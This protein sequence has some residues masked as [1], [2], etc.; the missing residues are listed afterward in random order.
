MFWDQ[1]NLL[2][3]PCFKLLTAGTWLIFAIDDDLINRV[4]FLYLKKAFH[5]LNR[6]ILFKELQLYVL[7]PH[8]VMW[9]KSHLSNRFQ[10]TCWWTLSDY[11]PVSCGEPQGSVLG[12][13]LFLAININE[14]QECELLMW[15]DTRDYSH[16]IN[17][18]HKPSCRMAQK[19]LHKTTRTRYCIKKSCCSFNQCLSDF[20]DIP[21]PQSSSALMFAAADDTSLTPSA[22]DPTILEEILKKD[23]D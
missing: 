4:L 21:T 11:L 2:W 9:F 20:S 14:M 7:D 16:L 10:G 1:C 3:L 22:Y 6:G 17:K 15:R 13:L 8:A 5:T 18:S 19:S 23:L 12:P